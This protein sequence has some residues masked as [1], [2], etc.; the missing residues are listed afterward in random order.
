MDVDT[1]AEPQAPIMDRAV[2]I[3]ACLSNQAGGEPDSVLGDD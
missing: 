1:S 3:C 2:R